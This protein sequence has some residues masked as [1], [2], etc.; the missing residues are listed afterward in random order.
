MDKT[1]AD[2]R[3]TRSSTPSV[4]VDIGVSGTYKKPRAQ[5]EKQF[6]GCYHGPVHHDGDRQ[7]HADYGSSD[8]LHLR[9]TSSYLTQLLQTYAQY[10]AAAK[11]PAF[12]YQL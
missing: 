8:E 4:N 3:Q 5:A 6:P 10:V 12:N 7:T 9:T 1:A 11:Y 2:L